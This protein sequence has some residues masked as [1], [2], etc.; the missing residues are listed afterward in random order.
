[1]GT[2]FV[3]A[4]PIGNLEDISLRSMQTLFSVDVIACEDTRHT[5]LLLSELRKR[6]AS[7]LSTFVASEQSAEPRLIRF[8]ERSEMQNTPALIETLEKGKSVALVSDAGT[9]LLSDPGYLLVREA[10]RR[11]IKVVPVPGPTAAITALT[12]S[13]LPTHQFLFLGYPPERQSH[14]L[15]LFTSLKSFAASKTLSPTVIFYCAPHKLGQT[16]TD[17]LVTLGN[18]DIVVA[19]EITKV[20]E[21][22]W[23]GNITEAQKVDSLAKGELVLLFQLQ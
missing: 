10:R 15:K 22:F 14:R 8:D 9:P 21:E 5:G 23:R 17:V 2:L 12:A 1:M 6:F 4:T 7:L 16:L 11:G 18:I 13:G 3:V 19:R 20:H